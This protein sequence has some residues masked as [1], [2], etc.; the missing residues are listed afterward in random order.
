MFLFSPLLILYL[1]FTF[2]FLPSCCP[3]WL[4]HLSAIPISVLHNA[5]VCFNRFYYA[6]PR[7]AVYRR[8]Y[9][10][11]HSPWP[12]C[13]SLYS[14]VPV[15]EMNCDLCLYRARVGCYHVKAVALGQKLAFLNHSNLVPFSLFFFLFLKF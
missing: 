7:E 6:P 11:S 8:W 13:C 1:S 5:D 2:R 3:V 12:V 10:V 14:R 4:V 9:I 15:L